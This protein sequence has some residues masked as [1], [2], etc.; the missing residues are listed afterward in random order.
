MQATVFM[1]DVRAEQNKRCVC[2]C[3]AYTLH[4]QRRTIPSAGMFVFASQF[5]LQKLLTKFPGALYFCHIA[6]SGMIPTSNPM[7]PGLKP[8]SVCLPL[9][10]IYFKFV[11]Y[12]PCPFRM[13]APSLESW[14]R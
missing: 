3:V 14:A 6:Y 7:N 1:I 12:H 8:E 9:L 13:E 11:E 2:F 4:V 10:G 5:C